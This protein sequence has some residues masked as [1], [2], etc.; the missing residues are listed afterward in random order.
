MFDQFRLPKKDRFKSVL[1]SPTDA[2]KLFKKENPR[3]WI[4]CEKII[5]QSEGAPHVANAKDKRPELVMQKPDE[6]FDKVEDW[7][8][9][10]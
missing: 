10:L 6:G 4:K 5:T 3:C 9:F 8:E 1:I 7:E 2:E